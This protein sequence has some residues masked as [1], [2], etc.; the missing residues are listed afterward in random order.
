[1]PR[2]VP[3]AAAIALF[4]LPAA[5]SAQRAI[6][7]HARTAGELA[8]LCAANPRDPRGASEVNYCHG[9]AQGVADVLLETASGTKPYFLFPTRRP[10]A[11]RR[12]RSSWNGPGQSRITPE[13]RRPVA[14]CNSWVSGSPA[15]R[16][17]A[18]APIPPTRLNHRRTGG[19]ADA[20][21]RGK[22]RLGDGRRQRHWRSR[23]SSA[24]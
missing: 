23:R 9:F 18:L 20:E 17:G 3:P 2:L 15:N 21:A 1:M 16:T 24:R 14:W 8:Q 19:P 7:L 11:P 13:C 5:A 22:N 12:S 10:P 4:L 6:D